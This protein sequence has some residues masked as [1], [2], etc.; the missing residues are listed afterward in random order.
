LVRERRL[1]AVA[2]I[3]EHA[4]V[5]VPV[6]ERADRGGVLRASQEP[7]LLEVDAGVVRRFQVRRDVLRADFARHVAK[8]PFPLKRAGEQVADR[9]VQVEASRAAEHVVRRKVRLEL[10]EI[11]ARDPGPETRFVHRRLGD[12]DDDVLHAVVL[13]R[14]VDRRESEEIRFVEIPLALEDVRLAVQVPRLESQRVADRPDAHALVAGDADLA[15]RRPPVLRQRHRH[16]AGA[17]DA[18]DVDRRIDHRIAVAQVPELVLEHHAHR[19]EQHEVERLVGVQQRE[20]VSDLVRDQR[21]VV[22]DRDLADD[23]RL[24][25]VDVEGEANCRVPR[26]ATV[27][28]TVAS[29]KP[30]FQ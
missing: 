4:R 28:S 2:A 24:V 5:D 29:R 19:V 15:D 1:A 3:D 18:V 22:L 10:E 6:H 11:H 20:P 7:R 23:G 21:R 30:R 9:S 16:V 25:L 14:H 13:R 26:P 8:E 27:V 12:V 17:R